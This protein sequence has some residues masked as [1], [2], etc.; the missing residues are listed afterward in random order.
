[1]NE[2]PHLLPNAATLVAPQTGQVCA[3]SL[4][5]VSPASMSN[6]TMPETVA[7]CCDEVQ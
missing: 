7:F 6:G 5:S 4:C 1:M 3:V 2:D